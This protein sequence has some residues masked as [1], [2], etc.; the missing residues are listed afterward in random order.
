MEDLTIILPFTQIRVEGMELEG[1]NITAEERAAKRNKV[2]NTPIQMEE[3]LDN[4]N[5]EETKKPRKSP[6]IPVVTWKGKLALD[7]KEPS[8]GNLQGCRAA[9]V[10]SPTSHAME[11]PLIAFLATRNHIFRLQVR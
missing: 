8:A 1:G 3:D 2:S 5:G 11:S 6:G 10:S 7:G 9:I 4:G